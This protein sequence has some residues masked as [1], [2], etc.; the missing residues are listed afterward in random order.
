MDAAIKKRQKQNHTAYYIFV[1]IIPVKYE[2]L[3]KMEIGFKQRISSVELVFN[4]TKIFA[5]QLN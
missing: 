3:K 1:E 2:G 4:E 5:R